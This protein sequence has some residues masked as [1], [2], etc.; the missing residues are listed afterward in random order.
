MTS[1]IHSLEVLLLKQPWTTPWSTIN[2]TE[3]RHQSKMGNVICKINTDILVRH[4]LPAYAKVCFA[5]D[6]N[7][8]QKRFYNG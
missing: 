6:S 7:Y 5:N 2:L 3:K 1:V 4:K 8:H